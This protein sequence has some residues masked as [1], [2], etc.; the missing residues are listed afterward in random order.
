MKNKKKLKVTIVLYET[1]VVN[2][3]CYNVL[4]MWTV[5]KIKENHAIHLIR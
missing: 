4:H 2:T 3:Y 5:G 1:L